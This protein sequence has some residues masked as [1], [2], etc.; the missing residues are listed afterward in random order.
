[1]LA[2]QKVMHAIRVWGDCLRAGTWNR[3][4][5]F[6]VVVSLPPWEEEQWYR[7]EESYE[8]PLPA[9]KEKA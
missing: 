4:S 5:R 6:P 1:M 2:N 7:L 3:Y 8:A 9:K